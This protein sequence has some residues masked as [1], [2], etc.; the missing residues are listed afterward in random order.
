MLRLFISIF[1]LL[2][3]STGAATLDFERHGKPVNSLSQATLEKDFKPRQMRVLEPHNSEPRTYIGIPLASVLDKVY[4][5]TWRQEEELL[6]NCAD[7]YRASIPVAQVLRYP[8]LLAYAQ[9]GNMPFTVNNIAQNELVNL[10]PYYLVWPNLQHA[11]LQ[12][13]GSTGWP[14]QVVGIDII[15]FAERFPHAAPPA[16]SSEASHKGFLA[17]RDHCMTCHTVNGEGGAKAP[18]LN[19]PSSVTQYLKPEWLRR[20]ILEPG[21]VRYKTSM[22]GL[23]KDLANREQIADDIISYLKVMADNK[24]KPASK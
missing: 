16:N 8:P 5:N 23:A 20:W 4:G 13:N 12:K 24:K 17:F 18:E 22:P 14:Y 9:A 3:S 19:Y 6:F 10:G 7:G 1:L 21:T 2:Y 11:V 15:R